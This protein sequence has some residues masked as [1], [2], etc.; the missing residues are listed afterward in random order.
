MHIKVCLLLLFVL[1]GTVGENATFLEI[2]PD[3]IGL[4]YG[5]LVASFVNKITPA[6]LEACLTPKLF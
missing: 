6:V 5:F 4:K 2:G 1:T 3:K